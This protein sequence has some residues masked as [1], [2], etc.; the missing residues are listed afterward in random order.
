MLGRGCR[1]TRTLGESDLAPR[2]K[3]VPRRRRW[4]SLEQKPRFLLEARWAGQKPGSSVINQEALAAPAAAYFL[5]N[6]STRPAVSTIFCLP[7]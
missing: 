1:R 3:D 4:R 2:D 5:R 6:L 7:V